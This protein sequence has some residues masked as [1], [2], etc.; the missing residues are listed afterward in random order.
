MSGERSLLVVCLAAF[1][2]MIGVGMIVA[3]LPQ[4]MLVF[5]GSLRDVGLI[6]S[7]FAVSY[8]L[9]LLPIGALA[10][11]FGAKTFLVIGYAF[12]CAAGLVFAFA[13]SSVAILLGRLIQGVGEAPVWALGPALL[14][15]MYAE[16][17]GRAI[18]IYN[19]A[20]HGGL[21]AGP[22]LGILLFPTGEGSGPFLVFAGLCFAAGATVLVFLPRTP[23]HAGRAIGSVPSWRHLVRLLTTSGPIIA[24]V[25][26]LLYG[27]G[28][29]VVISVLP[30]SLILH[31]AFDNQDVG[32]FFVVFYLWI[33]VAQLIVGPL[34]DR[35]GRHRFMAAG[36]AFAALGFGV[37]PW[38]PHPWVYGPFM[39][40]SIGLGTFCVASMAYLSETVDV[41]LRATVSGGYYVAWGIGYFLGPLVVGTVGAAVG[42]QAGYLLLAGSY[43]VLAATFGLL[44]LRC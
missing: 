27:A 21:T 41:S 8:V 35:H 34:S 7:V 39:L 1:L 3:I 26:I 2:L 33:S 42:W 37:L 14:S 23:R 25:G 38:A 12:C 44:R 32:V 5:S 6:A 36:L 11:R 18:G 22:M 24:L 10:D 4:R 9:V 30:A 29:G 19:A 13:G 16:A 40:A 17:K 20:I 31:R 28:Y 15:L 43:A